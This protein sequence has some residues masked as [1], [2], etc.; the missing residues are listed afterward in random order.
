MCNFLTQNKSTLKVCEL[1]ESSPTVD[2][3]T[4]INPK[5]S[6]LIEF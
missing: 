3:E 1:K 2:L 5:S 6:N 4:L